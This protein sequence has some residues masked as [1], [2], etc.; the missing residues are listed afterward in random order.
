MFDMGGVVFTLD[1]SAAIQRLNELGIH[2]AAERLDPYTQ[3]GIFGDLERGIITPE[4]FR[5]E[6]S[7]IAGRELTLEDCRYAWLGYVKEVPQRNL[8]LLR[9]LRREGYRLL[10]LSNTNPFMWSWANSAEFDGNGHPITSYFDRCYLSFEMKM[11]KPDDLVFRH[12]LMNEKSFP[13][14]IFFVDDGPRNVAQASQI[15][16]QTFCPE[17]GADW[18]QTIRDYIQ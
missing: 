12:V 3:G 14:N 16:F 2:D 1:Q 8:E 11:M 5:A 18:T 4:T 7:K 15:G 6:L 9:Q 10:L 17:N 13:S